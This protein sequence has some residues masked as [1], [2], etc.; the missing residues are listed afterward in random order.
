MSPVNPLFIGRF[1]RKSL[2]T[3]FGLP[4]ITFPFS[5]WLCYSYDSSLILPVFS[6]YGIQFLASVYTRS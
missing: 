1:G 6:F 4:Q 5:K 2:R 3:S